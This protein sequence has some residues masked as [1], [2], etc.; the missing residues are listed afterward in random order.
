MS[1]N[2]PLILD[3]TGVDI[4]AEAA[5]LRARG[6]VTLVELPGGIRAWSVPDAALLKNLLTD[7]RVSKSARQHWPAFINGEVPQDWALYPWV[8]VSSM[9]TAYGVD[10]RRL[11]KLVAPAFTHRR[12]AAMQPR[13][14]RI[15]TDL[16]DGLA[17]TPDGESVD[18]R[19][20][21]AYPLPIQVISELL[22]VPE[23]LNPA[24]R[25]CV[26]AF[27]DTT[28]TPG[29]SITKYGEMY[30]LMA[31]L[32]ARRQRQ[33]GDDMI[34]VLIAARDEDDGSTLTDS[35]LMD[36]LMLVISAGHET[37]VNLLDQAVFTL[38][39]HPGELAKLAAEA[40]DWESVV[41][42]SLRYEAP[43]AQ[44]PLRYAVEDLDIDGVHIAKG[45]AI[46]ASYAAANRDP[47]LHGASANEFDP[48]RE[49]KEHLAFGYGA[50]HC[51]GAPLARLEAG[52]AL[53]A[54][55]R[56]FPE[57]SLAVEPDELGTVPSFISNGH[58]RLPVYLGAK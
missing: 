8:A 49:N 43:V 26:D 23:E 7:P 20:S 39:T 56:R 5:R 54:L 11:R 33:P 6:P 28:L 47:K 48:S 50:H 2:E 17:K 41:E 36:T 25:S 3:P 35:E 27:F 32:V 24:L 42:E 30:G 9:F 29:E 53:P 51:L 55:F 13:I 16:L 52:V 44:L 1:D 4:Q 19:E 21:F 34:S 12:T 31:E 15:T 40:A 10:H 46:L 38:L 45:E 37:T 22:G 14:E 57:L 58:R 18:L